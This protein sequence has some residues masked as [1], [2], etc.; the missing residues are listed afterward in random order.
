MKGSARLAAPKPVIAALPALN[1]PSLSKSAPANI[2]LLPSAAPPTP[3]ALNKFARL[4]K[5]DKP[6]PPVNIPL[7]PK[8]FAPP[9]P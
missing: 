5:R 8:N 9:N 2:P 3:L 7:P 4:P 1:L 6:W